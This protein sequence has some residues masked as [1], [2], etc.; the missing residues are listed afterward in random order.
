MGDGAAGDGRV[1]HVRGPLEEAP[2]VQVEVLLGVGIEDARA[3]GRQRPVADEGHDQ[4]LAPR[5]PRPAGRSPLGPRTADHGAT[6][7][8]LRWS[9][10]IGSAACRETVC[11]YV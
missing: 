11:Q 5:A 7:D 10:E 3:P 4:G 1:P 2:W 8:R 9:A 6:A